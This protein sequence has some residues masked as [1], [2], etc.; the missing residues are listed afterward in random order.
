MAWLFQRFRGTCPFSHHHSSRF[1]K[2][3][4][5]PGR[6]DFPSPVGSSSFPQRTFPGLPRFKHSPAYTPWRQGYTASS[7]P[8]EISTANLALSPDGAPVRCP[9]L[10]ESPFARRGVLLGT[11]RGQPRLGKRYP[12]LFAHIGSCAPPKHSRRLCSR[13]YDES[14]QVTASPR[15]GVGGSRRYLHNPCI[16]AWSHTPPRLLSASTRFFL[17]NIGLTIEVNRSARE[18][19]SMLCNFA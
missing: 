6:S 18:I 8:L 5:H 19:Y 12:P 17:R 13:L 2:P 11:G 3:P 10:T 9:P 16:G 4:S 1:R 15:L 7:T 14:L